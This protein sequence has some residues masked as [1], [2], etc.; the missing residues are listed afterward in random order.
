MVGVQERA[1]DAGAMPEAVEPGPV[2]FDRVVPPSGN[3]WFARR[4]F[5]LGPARAG[6]IVRF[7][8]GVDVIHRNEVVRRFCDN[9]LCPADVGGTTVPFAYRRRDLTAEA[10]AV[11]SFGQAIV[12]RVTFGYRFDRR[13]SDAS[14][15]S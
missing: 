5:W 4:Q 1:V 15:G 3:L 14:V 8:A 6:Q 12:Q 9:L 11:R 10:G 7:W 2:E 13:R